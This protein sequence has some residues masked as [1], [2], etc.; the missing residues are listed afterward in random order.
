MNLSLMLNSVGFYQILK[1]SMIPIVCV[2]KWILQ[3]KYYSREVEM[4]VLVVVIGVVVCTIMDVKVNT[5]SFICACVAVF[6]TLMQQISI[7]SLQKKY[8]IGSF[9]LLS[10]TAPI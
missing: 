5:K 8:S 1:L 10:R 6:F 9:E 3:S 7:C 2:M 4:V